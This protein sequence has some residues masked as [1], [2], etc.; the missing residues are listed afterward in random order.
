PPGWAIRFQ[1]H[2]DE[3]VG[4]RSCKRISARGTARVSTA[5]TGIETDRVDRRE[6]VALGRGGC[7]R[8]SIA[9]TT[10]RPGDHHAAFQHI[11]A[12][13]GR[14]IAPAPFRTGAA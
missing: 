12:P 10:H 6:L 11:H 5:G 2:A 1:Y 8:V 3:D 4:A 13:I 7:H 9:A 14:S